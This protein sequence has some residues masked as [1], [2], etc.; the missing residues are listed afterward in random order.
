MERILNTETLNNIGKTVRVSGWLNIVRSH[1][2]IVFLDLRDRSGILQVVC[3]ADM[4]KD[5]KEE[6]VLNIFGEVKKR[7]ERMIN[8]DLETGTVELEAKEIKVLSKAQTLPFDLKDLKV[9]LPILLDY[10]PLTLRNQKI[11]AIFK[12]QEQVVE[13]FRR[14]LK[15]LDFTEFQAPAIVDS[16]TQGG[17]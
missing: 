8:L 5:L 7:P 13:S 16:A 17:R 4:A 14:T 1:G 11:S 6:D 10:R 15:D 3:G 9:S 12:I 2:K